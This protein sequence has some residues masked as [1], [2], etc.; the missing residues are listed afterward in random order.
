MNQLIQGLRSKQEHY[1][2]ALEQGEHTLVLK[3]YV[4]N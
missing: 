1:M 4:S 2:V 3:N